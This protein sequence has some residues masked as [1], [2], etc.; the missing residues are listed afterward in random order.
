MTSATRMRI[1][2]LFLAALMAL[3]G[4]LLA[5]AGDAAARVVD[6]AELTPRIS[7]IS[8]YSPAMNRVVR[9]HVLHPPGRPAYPASTCC[10][11][12]AAPRT[13][14]AGTTTAV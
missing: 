14:S 7:L 13:G 11:A 8:F 4:L 6:V 5:P 3:A 9:S 1:V 12:R 10:P 2:S